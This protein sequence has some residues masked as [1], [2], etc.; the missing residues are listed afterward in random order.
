[1]ASST[2]DRTYAPSEG[3]AVH[4]AVQ[5]TVIDRVAG[6]YVTG[7]GGTL[8]AAAGRDLSLLAAAVANAASADSGG[9]TLLSA[10][11]DLTLGTV[12]ETSAASTSSKGNRWRQDTRTEVGSTLA[13]AGD[14]TLAAGNDLTARA[15]SVVAGGALAASA[16][17]DLTITTGE[18]ALSSEAW[19]KSSTSGFLAKRSKERLDTLDETTAIASTFSGNTVALAAGN[20]LTV[21]GSS[22]VAQG[23]LTAVAGHDLTIES[24][25]E[26]H[27]ETHFYKEKESGLFGSGGIGVT[28]GSRMLSTDQRS[29]ATTA[30]GSTLGSVEGNV[31]LVA[32]NAYTQIGSEVLAPG[33]DIGVLAKSIAIEEARETSHTSYEMKAKQ[34]GLTVAITSPVIS[35]VQTIG[36]MAQAASDTSDGRMHALAAASAGLAGYQGYK[37]IEAGQGQTINGKDNQIVT[38]KDA[39]GNLT[40]RDANAADKAGG[41]NLSLSLGASKSH[42][43]STATSD[44]AAGSTLAAGGNVTLI[45][46]GGGAESDIRIQG[47]KVLAGQDVTL[48][49]D[50]AIELLAARN[51]ASQTSKNSS[52][53]AS[54]GV[55]IGTN[56]L[57]FNIGAS[58]G[59]GKANGSDLAWTNTHVQAG[60]TLTLVSGGDTTLKGAVAGGKQ[61]IAEVGGNLL[62]ESLQDLSTYDSKQGSFGFSLSIPI[63]P[64]TI[65]GSVSGGSSKVKSDYASVTEQTGLLAGDGGFN[66]KV[67]GDTTL[68]GAVIA[69][70]QTALDEARNAFATGGAL[71]LEDIQNH[72]EYKGSG[73]SV[74]IGT[75]VSFDGAWKP[76]GT[77]AGVG[78]TSDSASSTTSAGISGIAGNTETRTGDPQT[79]IA[80][81]FDAEKVQKEIDAQVKITQTF[82]QQAS[83]AVGDYAKS[84]LE[85][86]TK[87][88]AQGKEDE[89]RA[90]EAQWGENGT[91]RLA[92]H[93]VIGGLTGGVGGAAG[94]FAGTLTAPAVAE[95]LQKSG[96]SGPLADALTALASTATGAAVG[97]TAG[98]ASSLNEV[99]NNYLTH[100]QIK[101]KKQKLDNAKSE[102]ERQDI[103]KEYADI[104]AQQRAEAMN[105]LIK[106]TCGSVMTKDAIQTAFNE[107]VASCAPPRV[108]GSEQQ[109]SIAELQGIYAKAEAVQPVFPVE[110]AA[111]ILATGGLTIPGTAN[112]INLTTLGWAGVG[113]TIAGVFDAAG[114]YTQNGTI[115]WEQSIFTAITSG[116]TTP[117]GMRYGGYGNM[118][119]GAI[120]GTVNTAF[121]NV[122]Y[123][124]TNSIIWGGIVGGA[125]ASA[126][127][128]AGNTISNRYPVFQSNIPAVLQQPNMTGFYLGNIGGGVLQGIPGF[129][130]TDI[131]SKRLP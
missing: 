76:T 59:K 29:T 123:G 115:R 31:T 8:V 48:L 120:T 98:A 1:M 79:G 28:I 77:S 107:L 82:G 55:S 117:L 74:N 20:D 78:S 22:I 124:D 72:A 85:E 131:S 19:S 44:T 38:G 62:L 122:Y 90:I 40:S 127:Y 83:Q 23:D 25:T 108:C 9:A 67:A 97:G 126:G 26:T 51:T 36:Q 12:T 95:Q 114:Q 35:A 102:K 80:K 110:T 129:F 92:A 118:A 53:S 99:A 60:E 81:I 94:A 70:T 14:L 17:H 52:S 106:G 43:M 75:S 6:L 128:T 30:V 73:A 64:G 121:K 15:A 57:L 2:V 58:Q 71:T 4:A 113:G 91:L 93:T 18:A 42:S 13:A 109:A 11:R 37:A 125:S 87:L 10:G 56:G 100:P 104:D 96:L 32:G 49:A 84:Q 50:D 130:N 69:S 112:G 119:L 63:G 89:A 24:A 7:E 45:A 47:A 105:C 54:V 41:I 46:T 16:G 27:A 68:K 65:S 86:A 39:G 111:A 116:I 88:R 103:E 66:V 34:S 101:E 33:G 3:R 61:V 5:T 21:K